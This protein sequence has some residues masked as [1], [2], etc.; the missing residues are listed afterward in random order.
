MEFFDLVRAAHMSVTC[1]LEQEGEP[2][3]EEDPGDRELRRMVF[4][5]EVRWEA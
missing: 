4:G 5:Y 3:F 2:M 1:V